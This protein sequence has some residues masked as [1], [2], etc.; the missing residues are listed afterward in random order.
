VVSPPRLRAETHYGVQAGRLTGILRLPEAEA[1]GYKP[2][3]F[4]RENE[5][6]RRLVV[7]NDERCRWRK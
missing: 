3:R 7:V 6:Q 5:T 2:A 1:T 4:Q